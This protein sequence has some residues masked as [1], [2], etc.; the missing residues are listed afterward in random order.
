MNWRLNLAGLINIPEH[1]HNA[2]FYSKIFK[3]INPETQAKF[4][5]LNRDL[6]HLPIDVA[7]WAIDWDCVTDKANN[8][9]FKWIVDKQIVPMDFR[10]KKIFNNGE[11]S[12][13]VKK[14]IKNYNYEFN[15]KLFNQRKL[16]KSK[17]NMENVI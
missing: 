3:Y 17:M 2:K 9:P 4:K 6:K 15:E 10:L 7:T 13:H 14:L 1:F 8:K 11:Y 5:A 12:N 16:K